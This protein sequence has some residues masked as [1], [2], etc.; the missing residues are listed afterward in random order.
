MKFTFEITNF[1]GA[2]ENLRMPSAFH[3]E[4][5][6]SIGANWDPDLEGIENYT[7]NLLRLKFSDVKF[8]PV[9]PENSLSYGIRAPTI[10]HV[11]EILDFGKTVETGHLLVHCEMGI[12]RSSAA[13]LIVLA[14]HSDPSQA[15]ELGKIVQKA[16][17]IA[18]P[19][20]MMLEYADELLG[21]GGALAA[22]GGWGSYESFYGRTGSGR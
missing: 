7:G 5:L 6:I 22:L 13:T 16:R 9:I 12:S 8:K 1:E 4:H 10:E 2:E 3:P 14:T 18:R 19:N 17:P 21:W 15:Q 11:Q 20:N